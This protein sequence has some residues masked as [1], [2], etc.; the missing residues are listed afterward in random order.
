MT[1][2]YIEIPNKK[3]GIIFIYNYDINDEYVELMATMRS[4]GLSQEKARK[5]L[6][7]LS[8]YNTGM[9]L[10]IEDLR[11]SVVFVSNTTSESEFWDTA[12]H[13]IKH[14]AD[15]I[16]AY[17]DVKWDSED[18]AYL[19]GFLTKQLVELIGKPCRN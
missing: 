15:H 12:I 8:N 16:I 6:S 11:M 13:E 19:T 5:A 2:E 1:Q 3:W 9:T 14:V 18:A 17:Y 10:S 4:F 7:I